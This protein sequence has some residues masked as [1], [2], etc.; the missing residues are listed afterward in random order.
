M[1]ERKQVSIEKR[2]ASID[3]REEFG[4]WEGDTV[5]LGRGGNYLVTLVERKT[6]F[7]LLKAVS[8]KRSDP[9]QQ[10]IEELLSRV[11]KAV[12]S[13]TLDNGSEFAKHSEMAANLSADIY[14]T[15]PH[16]PWERGTN[17]NTNGLVRQYFPKSQTFSSL[18][19]SRLSTCRQNIIVK[20]NENGGD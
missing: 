4:H 20:Q 14:F 13:L 2:P 3:L 9:V 16:S 10:A 6:R 1:H 7:L 11:P 18:D 19:H 12:R 8:N 17:E 5:E 15:H